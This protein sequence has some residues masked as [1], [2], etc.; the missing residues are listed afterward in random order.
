MRTPK[1]MKAK[2]IERGI[3]IIIDSLESHLPYCYGKSKDGKKFH[4]GCVL[5]Y[6]EA[7]LILAKLYDN[8]K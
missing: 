3:R 2:E 5:E 1:D 8:D 6:A 4:I 7:I